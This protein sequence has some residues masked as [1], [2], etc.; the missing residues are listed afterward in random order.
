MAKGFRPI[1]WPTACAA[2]ERRHGFDR[3]LGI[4]RWTEFAGVGILPQHAPPGF[5]L[6]RLRKLHGHNAAIAPCDAASADHRIENRVSTPRHE[7]L[8]RRHHSTVRKTRTRK[9]RTGLRLRTADY[10]SAWRA[11]K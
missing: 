4:Q 10:Q 1:A 3:D 9:I 2:P 11:A 5:D 8:P 7:S 6:A